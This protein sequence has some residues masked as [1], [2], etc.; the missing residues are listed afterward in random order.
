MLPPSANSDP[1]SDAFKAKITSLIQEQLKPIVTELAAQQKTLLTISHYSGTITTLENIRDLEQSVNFKVS[2]VLGFDPWQ[3]PTMGTNLR[4]PVPADPE[5]TPKFIPVNQA[6]PAERAAQS[7]ALIKEAGMSARQIGVPLTFQDFPDH[8]SMNRSAKKEDPMHA[9]IPLFGLRA[10]RWRAKLGL[11]DHAVPGT[12][13]YDGVVAPPTGGTGLRLYNNRARELK[14]PMWRLI[15]QGAD[16][17]RRAASSHQA[18]AQERVTRRACKASPQVPVYLIQDR[19]PSC[20]PTWR[21]PSGL[22]PPLLLHTNIIPR[23]SALRRTSTMA[24]IGSTRST[25]SETSTYSSFSR[26]STT[27]TVGSEPPPRA[28]PSS[29]RTATGRTKAKQSTSKQRSSSTRTNSKTSTVAPTP[30]PIPASSSSTTLKR[31]RRTA[32][33]EDTADDMIT[34]EKEDEEEAVAAEP[35][36]KRRKRSTASDTGSESTTATTLIGNEDENGQ[37]RRSTRLT[38]ASAAAPQ[39]GPAPRGRATKGKKS[40]ERP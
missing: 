3:H 27:A 25:T 4:E 23:P 13:V 26:I 7:A 16:L 9:S 38:R 20:A 31:G 40:N 10:P 17:G 35:A 8:P 36:S 12:A 32:E 11:D 24:T 6:T 14:L 33:L 1:V 5:L 29:S 39:P 21:I 30:T 18:L 19:R 34:D 15:E 22:P 2:G 37:P 28:P